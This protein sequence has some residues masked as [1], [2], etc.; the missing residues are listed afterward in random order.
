MAH[1]AE[2]EDEHDMYLS[3]ASSATLIFDYISNIIN[4]ACLAGK[5]SAWLQERKEQ[6]AVGVSK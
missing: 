1:E 3:D 2:S 4:Q 5:Y 6:E